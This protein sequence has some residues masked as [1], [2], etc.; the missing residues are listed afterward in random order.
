MYG[1]VICYSNKSN[2]SKTLLFCR[3]G[4]SFAA[5]TVLSTH[6]A[7]LCQP[8]SS[9]H[10]F[11]AVL[12]VPHPSS[13][14]FEIIRWWWDLVWDWQCHGGSIHPRAVRCQQ[15][16]A[17]RQQQHPDLVVT[18]HKLAP[19]LLQP[20]PCCFGQ[21]CRCQAQPCQRG[22]PALPNVSGVSLYVWR[23]VLFAVLAG[24]IFIKQVVRK[25][26]FEIFLRKTE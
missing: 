11:F 18:D 21:V 12:L 25:K 8:L 3:Y 1:V 24:H 19:M 23:Y 14:M 16:F 9:I 7:M 20:S 17:G 10:V 6:V 2:Q 4:P 5:P 22:L 13:V 15:L 26:G